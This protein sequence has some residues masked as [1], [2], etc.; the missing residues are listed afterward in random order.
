VP[1]LV[2]TV[3]HSVQVRPS[4]STLPLDATKEW[5]GGGDDGL[6]EAFAGGDVP[7]LSVRF[8]VEFVCV[9]V[10]SWFEMCVEGGEGVMFGVG[11]G[12]NVKDHRTARPTPP[13]Q[14]VSRNYRGDGLKG[15]EVG[16][17]IGCFCCGAWGSRIVVM[18]VFFHC[19]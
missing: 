10:G 13:L 5:R 19:S 6:D 16:T 9:E 1:R 4:T 17:S 14:G 8:V 18:D 12:L 3:W 15:V 2:A 7:V 11:V